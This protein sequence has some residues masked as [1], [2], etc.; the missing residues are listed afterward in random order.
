MFRIAALLCALA[1]PALAED[2]CRAEIN[3]T[4]LLI[5]REAL[6]RPPGAIGLTERLGGWPGRGLDRLRG[7]HPTCDSAT[8]IAYLAQEVP[9]EEISG[10]CLASD[11]LLGFVLAPGARDYRGRCARTS[12]DRVSGAR[13]GAAA[14]AARAADVASG[15]RAEE[16]R[17]EAVLHSSGA[18]ILTGSAASVLSTL[19]SGTTTA[20][21]AALSAPALAGAAAVS[22]IAVGGAVYL[23]SG[24][25]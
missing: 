8:L 15:R 2:L 3:S 13:D 17:A 1:L 11:P 12:C 4:A 5:D 22:V 14:V 21:T 20:I 7:R 25:G 24:A 9:E 18:A 6:D 10:Y 19:G 23:C 16:G